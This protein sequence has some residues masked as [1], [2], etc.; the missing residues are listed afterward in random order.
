[1]SDKASHISLK[2]AEL[3]EVCSGGGTITNEEMHDFCLKFSS[4]AAE[5][6]L[7]RE[8]KTL[9]QVRYFLESVLNVGCEAVIHQ[10]LDR[11]VDALDSGKALTVKE[12]RSRLHDSYTAKDVAQALAHLIKFQ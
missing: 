4:V 5:P 11:I 1:M 3:A 9:E 6:D 12:I 10:L 2:I 8:Q 7:S